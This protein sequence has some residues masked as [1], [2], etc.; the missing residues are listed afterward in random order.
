M[1]QCPGVLDTIRLFR[2]SA[3]QENIQD[4][5]HDNQANGLALL[6]TVIVSANLLER[7]T[8]AMGKH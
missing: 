5:L 7:H 4:H 6:R 1:A 8:S 2:A 3:V